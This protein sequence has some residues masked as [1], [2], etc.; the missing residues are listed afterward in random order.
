MGMTMQDHIDVL[1]RPFRRN[2]LQPES[3]SSA[4][5]VDNERPLRVVVTI[6]AH[7]R[8]L[9]T[10]RTQFIEN[11]LRADVA[12][13]PDFISPGGEGTDIVRQPIVRVGQ[14]KNAMPFR[15]RIGVLEWWIDAG[16]LA[17]TP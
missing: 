12:E 4:H 13:M 6:P 2:M 14:D 15:G 7:H 3:H 5:Q 16:I 8:D 10:N 11:R 17:T 1:R 9:W